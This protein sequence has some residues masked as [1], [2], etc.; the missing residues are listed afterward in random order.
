MT[1][2]GT[3][4]VRLLAEKGTAPYYFRVERMKAGDNGWTLVK[5]YS[6]VSSVSVRIPGKGTYQI[7]VTV[8]DISGKIAIKYFTVTGK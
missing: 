7:K 1:A 5:D 8:T 6:E 3:V 2:G 4:K